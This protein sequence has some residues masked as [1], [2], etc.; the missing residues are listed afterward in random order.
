MFAQTFDTKCTHVIHSRTG[1]RVFICFQYLRPH[2]ATVPKRVHRASHGASGT[3]RGERSKGKSQPKLT[4]AHKRRNKLYKTENVYKSLLF[5]P[6]CIPPSL[7]LS[8]SA[9]KGGAKLPPVPEPFACLQLVQPCAPH[10]YAWAMDSTGTS[11]KEQRLA[12]RNNDWQTGA[13]HLQSPQL[14]SKS[15]LAT[16]CPAAHAH[17]EHITSKTDAKFAQPETHLHICPEARH[18]CAD[19]NLW[20]GGE[21]LSLQIQIHTSSA[22]QVRWAMGS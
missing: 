8:G 15:L 9:R 19:S 3:P 12:K 10:T 7:I 2:P 21:V 13:L 6:C 4:K 16:A 22:C 14:T 11:Q 5:L 1:A 17:H 18:S 20:G